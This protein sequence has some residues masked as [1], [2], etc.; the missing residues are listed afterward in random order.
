MHSGNRLGA[1]LSVLIALVITTG[2][3]E[4]N[5]GAIVPRLGNVQEVRLT[6]GGFRNV[7]L[8]LL[9]DDSGS[10]E[11]E[12]DILEERIAD[13]VRDLTTP[14]D[15]NG[16]GRA[17]WGAVDRLRVAIVTTD[18]GTSGVPAPDGVGVCEGLGDDGE[19]QSAASCSGAELGLQVYQTGE[20]AGAFA[21]RIGCIVDSLG[22]NGCGI[23]Q[24]LEAASRAVERGSDVPDG[25]PA[26][27]AIL[28]VLVL[29]DEEDC[30]LEQPDA[31]YA[32]FERTGRVN[33]LCQDAALGANGA[34]QAWL[35]SIDSLATR[36]AAGREDGSFVFGAITGLPIDLSG[37]SPATI[38]ADPRMVYGERTDSMNRRVPTAACTSENGDATPARRIVEVASRFERS[39][40]HSICSDDFGPAIQEVTRAI[41]Q[42]IGEFCLPRRIPLVGER[43]ECELRVKL[44]EGESCDRARGQTEVERDDG[45]A[46]CV[47]DQVAA[48]GST[49][50]GYFYADSEECPQIVFTDAARPPLGASVVASC[51]FETPR[52]GGAPPTIEEDAGSPTGP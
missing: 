46:V 20:D 30:S 37:E 29:S 41:A 42:Q 7:D 35:R 17:D 49:G 38:L 15:E 13:L 44:A 36:L 43:V 2:C 24:Q 52:D 8:V 45:R 3:F 11:E 50:Q 6:T 39:V 9:V 48:D 47:V 31:F 33:L 25:F 18:M 10:M 34:S 28:A 40:L 14:P 23:E 22:L 5:T 12:Q 26:E 21:A 16:D 1:V 4:R 19:Y 32:E 51:Y 27:D